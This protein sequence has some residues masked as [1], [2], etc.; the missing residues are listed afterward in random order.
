MK[1]LLS[2]VLLG[3][4]LSSALVGWLLSSPRPLYARDD[5]RAYEEGGDAERGRLVFLVGGCPSCH[6]TPGQPDPLRLGG[7]YRLKTPFGS[8]FPPNISPDER[9]GIGDWKVVDL[10]NALLAGVSPEGTHYYP[11]LPYT[12]Y[13]R[14]TLSDVRDL[15]AYLRT[16]SKVS[17]RAPQHRLAFPFSIRRAVGLWKLIYLGPPGLPPDPSRSET[18]NRG[19][20]LVE[21]P[22]HCAE[23]HS[24]RDMFGGIIASRRFA[25]GVT[26]DGKG[27]APNL[28][29][30][31]KGFAEWSKEDV[32]TALSLGLTPSGDSLGG[33]MAAE[34]RN[35]KQ[36]P[37][38]DLQAMAE[39][40]KSLPPIP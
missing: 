28:T 10:A 33:D 27:K 1:K 17:G 22:G 26:P 15:M 2:V 5:W 39:Y 31:A 37:E 35:L 25:G 6:M 4:A 7:G 8:F 9:D 23:C 12:S 32:E 16:L 38:A 18:W 34:V 29:Q 14:M 24:P 21:G 3:V 40:I 13:R 19:R 20:Y 30:A 11:A 36:L